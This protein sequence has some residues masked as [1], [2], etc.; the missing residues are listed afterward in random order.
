MI[1]SGSH[2]PG[3]TA[4]DFDLAPHTALRFE[5]PDDALRPAL[6]GYHV[7]DADGPLAQGSVDWMLPAWPAIRIR[8]D[9]APVRID[10]ARRSYDPVPRAALY[11]TTST[12]MR[13]TSYGGVTVGAEISPTG[14]SRL[15]A[16]PADRFRDRIVPLDSVWPPNVVAALVEELRASDQGPAVKAIFDRFF[17]ARLGPPS[18]D[19]AEIAAI[20]KLILDDETHDIA[21]AAAAVGIDVLTLRRL[22]TRHFGFTPKTLLMRTR[23]LR[24]FLR[25][26]LANDAR[27]N[28]VPAPYH[29]ASHFLRDSNRF[30]GTTPRRFLSRNSPHL[31]A[32]LRALMR[33]VAADRAA[34]FRA[35][36]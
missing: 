22:A 23:F 21:S 7:L 12:A 29:D 20:L 17:L 26:L 19:D 10:L 1:E 2:T 27:L 18:P 30:L 11:G 6:L 28:D 36:A 25:M 8:L 31:A 5:M 33:V 16:D 24:A 4:A 14:W 32:S 15:F 34:R 9:D 13:V 35:A 3:I